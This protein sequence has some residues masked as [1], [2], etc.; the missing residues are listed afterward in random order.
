MDNGSPAVS[1]IMP[2]YNAV[3]YVSAAIESVLDQTF[4]DFELILVDDG[5]TDGSGEICDKYAAADNRV[6]VI[7]KE[8]GGICSARNTGMRLAK[9][10][11]LAF[12]DHDD[13][14]LK[15]YLE[16][17]VSAAEESGAKLVKFS[18]TGEIW[19]NGKKIKEHT[20]RLED[21]EL[22]IW[23]LVNCYEVFN[24]VLRALWNGLYLRSI[25]IENGIT[26]NEEIKF[27]MEDYLFNL[28]LLEFIDKVKL[29][30]DTLFI[31]YSRYEQST[32]EK[33]APQRYADII[34]TA[35]EEKQ[36]LQK[37][38]VK[39]EKL[40]IRHQYQY[41]MMYIKTLTHP[42]NNMRIKQKAA[43]IKALNSPDKFGVRC[44]ASIYLKSV[45]ESP[46]RG[47]ITILYKYGFY[48]ILIWIYEKYRKICYTNRQ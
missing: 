26:F 4:T 18:Y 11:Y 7:H 30:S 45:F 33:Y 32:F 40:W 28:K 15:N 25:I 12:C 48:S 13:I 31:H 39:D 47:I 14:Y 17:A 29:I 21:K 9:G 1:V 42:D 6:I 10:K 27:G 24:C 23:E 34:K 37:I 19:N 3:K 22:N 8:N 46:K 38:N 41:L 2:V 5:A 43:M 36:F 20:Q 16:K 35:L 44:R